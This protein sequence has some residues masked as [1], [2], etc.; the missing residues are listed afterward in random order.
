MGGRR[1][2]GGRK[3]GGRQEEGSLS[4]LTHALLAKK[5]S[6]LKVHLIRA[7]Y[8]KC[9]P[10]GVVNQSTNIENVFCRKMK[11]YGI[12]HCIN[13]LG[14]VCFLFMIGTLAIH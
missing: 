10:V 12:N 14:D 5:Y 7:F 13:I 1:K 11:S 9:L 3:G 6:Y 2:V 8:L 4:T